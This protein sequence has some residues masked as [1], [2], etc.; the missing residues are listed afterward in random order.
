[1]PCYSIKI[2]FSKIQINRQN[3]KNTT[4]FTEIDPHKSL[5]QVT[6][7]KNIYAS[8]TSQKAPW[9]TRRTPST[10]EAI[11]SSSNQ[12]SRIWNPG[13]T[14]CETPH[15]WNQN[16]N[17]KRVR[18]SFWQTCYSD[19]WTLLTT[20]QTYQS[21]II[22]ITMEIIWG[23]AHQ[24]RDAGGWTLLHWKKMTKQMKTKSASRG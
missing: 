21:K 10:M 20:L 8:F 5:F 3:L 2:P 18:I 23:V 11:K 19:D 9:S 24:T 15:Q 17:E 4:N 7:T 1:M 16:K 13:L 22:M 14:V 12:T 6:K